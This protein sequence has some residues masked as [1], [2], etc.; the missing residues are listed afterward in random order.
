[1]KVTIK[2][3]LL[4]LAIAIPILAIA[5]HFVPLIRDQI[6]VYKLGP[7]SNPLRKKLKAPII[8]E[9]WILAS[10]NENSAHWIRKHG[11]IGHEGKTVVFFNCEIKKE[12]DLYILKPANN[13]FRRIEISSTF[14]DIKSLNIMTFTYRKGDSLELIS[15]QKADSLLI[16]EGIKNDW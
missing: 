8:P 4:I 3:L 6:C 11:Y 16:T 5:A 1:M 2:K 13:S 14:S 10:S 15:K 7:E 12:L 9:G